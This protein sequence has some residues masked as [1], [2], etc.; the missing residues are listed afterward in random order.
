MCHMT[1]DKT[2]NIPGLGNNRYSGGNAVPDLVVH[3]T[4]EQCRYRTKPTASG[5]TFDSP[6]LSHKKFLTK[7][8]VQ[9]LTKQLFTSIP[10]HMRLCDNPRP[11]L[12][13]RV[14]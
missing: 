11:G 4:V 9:P 12:Q 14:C 3:S 13:S 2:Q 5:E 8:L 1:A 10:I 7:C 6:S